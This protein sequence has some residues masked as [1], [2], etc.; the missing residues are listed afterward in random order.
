MICV[1]Y[2][3]I[4]I[5]VRSITRTPASESVP[6]LSAMQCTPIVGSVRQFEAIADV[7]VVTVRQYRKNQRRLDISNRFE[8]FGDILDRPRWPTHAGA[9]GDDRPRHPARER[10][11]QFAAHRTGFMC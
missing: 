5:A 3:P 11:E 7:L 8:M 10:D 2:G 1:Q 9:F 6:A 4:T